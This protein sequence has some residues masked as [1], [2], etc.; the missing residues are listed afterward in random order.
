MNIGDFDF[1]PVTAAVTSRNSGNNGQAQ[2]GGRPL[3]RDTRDQEQDSHFP[4]IDGLSGCS[5]I[6]GCPLKALTFLRLERL[7]LFNL[8]KSLAA[9]PI[10]GSIQG[11]YR[12]PKR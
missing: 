1:Q 8:C 9:W 5:A 11:S 7:Y 10:P 4:H 6:A 12:N 3:A 2:I